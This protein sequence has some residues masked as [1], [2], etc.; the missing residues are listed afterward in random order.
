MAGVDIPTLPGTTVLCA[1]RGAA[2][3]GHWI[4]EMLPVA[5]LCRAQLRAGEW[6]ALVPRAEGRLAAAVQDSLDLLD[7]PPAH[8]AM[9]ASTPQHASELLIFEGLTRHGVYVSPLVT[10]CLA[11][12]ASTIPAVGAE[13]LWVSRVRECRRFW[14]ET[15]LC[16]VLAGSGWTVGEPGRVPLRQQIALF[17]GAR[18]IAGVCGAGLTNLAFAA[19]GARVTNFVPAAMPETLFWL[20]SELCG[21]DYV[22]VRSPQAK[23]QVGV[24]AW[25]GA[26]VLG[27]PDVLAY[28]A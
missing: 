7:I 3:Y 10:D 19:P 13:R 20:L 16:A 5:W 18:H 2:N 12:L 17:K 21:H 27:L 14:N 6:R 26:L 24:T 15:E 9:L 8:V 4:Y 25:D 23:M 22:E 1:K 11:A 28:L